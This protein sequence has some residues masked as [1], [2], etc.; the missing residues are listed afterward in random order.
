[1]QCKCHTERQHGEIYELAYAVMCNIHSPGWQAFYIHIHIGRMLHLNLD[2]FLIGLN[3]GPHF[4]F[5]LWPY[6]TQEILA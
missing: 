6:V 3:L 1:M 4:H 5:L 2:P